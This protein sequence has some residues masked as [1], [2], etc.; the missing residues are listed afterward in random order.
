ME[1][2]KFSNLLLITLE[3]TDNKDVRGDIK[4][5]LTERSPLTIILFALI[6]LSFESVR[7]QIFII[8]I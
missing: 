7:C 1:T 3:E 5:P 8:I 6:F 4:F 2:F